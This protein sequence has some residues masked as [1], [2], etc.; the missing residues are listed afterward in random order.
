M[1]KGITL[2]LTGLPA[3]GKTTLARAVAQRVNNF[4]V[5]DSDEARRVITP[6][7]RYDSEERRLFYRSL[8]YCAACLNE[9]GINVIIAATGN[10]SE[11]RDYGRE[12]IQRFREVYVKCDVKQCIERDPKNLYAKAQRGLISTLPIRVKGQND[13]F[14]DD[15][16]AEI[17][18]Y[19]PPQ[20]PDLIIDSEHLSITE[21]TELLVDYILGELGE[22]HSPS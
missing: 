1:K 21:S 17:D 13:E 8:V 6:N 20:N 10:I 9:C 11:Y 12:H 22:T 15:R 4:W 18:V 7:P 14:V 2:W 3:S 5:I 19:M 16:F